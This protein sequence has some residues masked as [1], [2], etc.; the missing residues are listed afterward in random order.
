M[1]WRL[2]SH[3]VRDWNKKCQPHMIC[4]VLA[5]FSA[6][7]LSVRQSAN[8]LS[9]FVLFVSKV[10]Q[11]ICEG[12]LQLSDKRSKTSVSE[13]LVLSSRSVLTKGVR[14][15]LPPCFLM[16]KLS[17]EPSSDSWLFSWRLLRSN[18]SIGL[19]ISSLLSS[20]LTNGLEASWK[21]STIKA[22]LVNVEFGSLAG[23]P[24]G[25]DPKGFSSP[26]QGAGLELQSFILVT[27]E[28]LINAGWVSLWQLSFLLWSI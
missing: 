5:N 23:T 26:Q 18:P 10:S 22:C 6:S 13:M 1:K 7:K 27:A 17:W 16:T 11:Q 21:S 4:W 20:S 15:F 19:V 12:S 9:V 8:C 2:V 14:D 25:S 3:N 28:T 24:S